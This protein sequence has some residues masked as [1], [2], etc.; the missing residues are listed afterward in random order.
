MSEFINS[1]GSTKLSDEEHLKALKKWHKENGSLKGFKQTYGLRVDPV[2]G[3][4]MARAFTNRDG[5]QYTYNSLQSR[6]SNDIRRV[7][8]EGRWRD[9]L[10]VALDDLGRSNEFEEHSN[11]IKK[12]NSAWKRRIT[13]QNKGKAKADQVSRGHI[14]AM[15]K[16]GLDVP[17]NVME[18]NRGLNSGRQDFDD[19]PEINRRMAGSPQSMKE[20]VFK[21]DLKSADPTRGL[22]TQVQEN[23]LEAKSVNEIDDILNDA[24]PEPTVKPPPES[25]EGKIPSGPRAGQRLPVNRRTLVD[26][27]LRDIRGGDFRMSGLG[28]AAG[29]LM[30]PDAAKKIAEGDIIGGL[31]TGAS[32]FL[33]GEAAS[34]VLQRGAKFL[35][36]HA[37]KLLA[38]PVV[39]AVSPVGQVVGGYQVA[40]ELVKAGTGEGFVDKI[41]NVQNKELT[42]E[43]NTAAQET[44]KKLA[45]ERKRTGK[46]QSFADNVT[47]VI[48]KTAND[49]EYLVKN[50]LSI[51]GIK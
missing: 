8:Q 29:L 50:P 35:G 46:D 19:A 17:E 14:T 48:E 21:Q 11:T 39:Q 44:T 7:T 37:A 30:D 4:M 25:Y 3:P 12:G 5:Q 16:G 32:G 40:N 27:I 33:K 36:P 31:Q 13:K 2:K 23:I 24:H 42:R 28:G 43:I 26:K 38:S 49:L 41:K 47:N 15:N 9:E 18:E 51:F 6:S 10:K 20:W 45:A 22:S 34:Q 1:D